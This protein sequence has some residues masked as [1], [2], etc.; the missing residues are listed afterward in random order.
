MNSTYV[1]GD[2]YATDGGSIIRFTSGK[3]EGWSPK[4][5]PDAIIRPAPDY[6]LVA[7]VVPYA[8]GQRQNGEVY[9]LDRPN[10]RIVALD[11]SNGDYK[12]QYRLAGGLTDWSDMRGMYLIA[13]A[14]D[15][16]PPTLVWLSRDGLHQSTLVAVP[17]VAPSAAPS[18]STTPKPSASPVKVTPKPTKKP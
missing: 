12:G 11:K 15:T 13:G 14:A 18:A 6:S 3:S 5:P 7:S 17:D 10:V 8:I 4:A 16:E 2:L 9:V 1:D